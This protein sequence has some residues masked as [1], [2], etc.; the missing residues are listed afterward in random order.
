MSKIRSEPRRD[1]PSDREW[2][3]QV[4]SRASGAPLR[5]GNR[6]R[7]L[8]DAAENYPAWLTATANARD[9][10]DVEMYIIHEDAQGRSSPMR[11]FA[12]RLMGFAF[13]FVTGLCVGQMWAG[14]P[15]RGVDPWRDT[16]IEIAGPAVA[17]VA[18]AFAEAWAAAG[19]PSDDM[20]ARAVLPAAGDVS[21]R[22]VAT[23]PNTA[24]LCR[25]DQLVAAMARSTLW[26]TDAYF[27]GIAAYV[28][29]LRAAARDGV[30]VRLLVPGAS[31]IPLIRPFSRAGYRPLLE[32]GVRV[33]EWNGST[34]RRSC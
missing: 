6:I 3:N 2:A 19:G 13:A 27:A 32:A 5:N 17:D 10:I 16:G 29:A 22:V 7:L 14:D 1:R 26:L 25:I 30:D 20:P 12:R 15:A 11:C 23:V 9:T 28:E 31:D 33:F 4:F 8:K 24:G 21:L 18:E 34:S